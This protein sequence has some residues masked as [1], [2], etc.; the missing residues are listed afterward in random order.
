MNVRGFGAGAFGGGGTSGFGGSGFGSGAWGGYG[1]GGSG[2]GGTFGKSIT[3]PPPSSASSLALPAT[4]VRAFG[5]GM[6]PF[7]PQ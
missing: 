4:P 6:R 5:S 1:F 7:F 3:L 2:G